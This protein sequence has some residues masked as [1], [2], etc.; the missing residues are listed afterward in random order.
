MSC[1]LKI[2]NVFCFDLF[3]ISLF[4]LS[5]PIVAEDHAIENK[6]LKLVTEIKGGLKE[7]EQM[8][9]DIS[10]KFPLMKT[11]EL[12][13]R[14][15]SALDSY[16]KKD[17]KDYDV[18]IKTLTPSQLKEFSEYQ[19]LLGKETWDRQTSN[20]NEINEMVGDLKKYRSNE[21][22]Y[23]AFV[24]FYNELLGKPSEAEINKC[25]MLKEKINVPE[26][27]IDY[28]MTYPKYQGLFDYYSSVLKI[29]NYPS[30]QQ[31]MK[32]RLSLSELLTYNKSESD[33][34]IQKETDD[35]IQK[36][37]ETLST[38]NIAIP[39]I[40]SQ[41]YYRIK[42]FSECMQSPEKKD[43]IKKVL[44][45]SIMMR[46]AIFSVIIGDQYGNVGYVKKIADKIDYD[47]FDN[48]WA[49]LQEESKHITES[50]FSEEIRKRYEE[51]PK[52]LSNKIIAKCFLECF[53]TPYLVL[54][55]Q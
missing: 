36:S 17:S 11:F 2:K 40:G 50:L 19:R 32:I 21:K 15:F 37:Q 25:Q 53:F 8:Q 31:A 42:L 41:D 6:R 43:A 34:K 24:S 52:A 22:I 12:K 51:S 1:M 16:F 39:N 54:D 48:Y 29:I 5:Y 44:Q 18:Y 33:K 38:P 3:L 14:I 13:E 7:F 46:K 4:I 55:N 49:V 23:L 35:F 26:P 20:S 45:E 10:L 47:N 28:W 9:K 27:V 30:E